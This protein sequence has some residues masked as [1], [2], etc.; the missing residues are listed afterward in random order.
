MDVASVG[1]L[2]EREPLGVEAYGYRVALFLLDDEVH[3]LMARCP[4]KGGPLDEGYVKEDLVVC[5]WHGAMF[6]LDT[7]ECVGGPAEKAAVAFPVA[8][9][10]DR[11]LVGPPPPGTEP[12]PPSFGGFFSPL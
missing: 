2:D 8:I 12:P 9:E 10:D 7:G 5:P 3:A 6:R 11:V 4:H 1:D